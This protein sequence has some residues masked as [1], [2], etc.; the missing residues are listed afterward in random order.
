MAACSKSRPRATRC[1]YGL[2]IAT[3]R[4]FRGTRTPRP[5]RRAARLGGRRILRL[6]PVSIDI[7]GEREEGPGKGL[8]A[9]IV[10]V[11]EQLLELLGDRSV[12][13]KVL[14]AP[15][16]DDVVALVRRRVPVVVEASAPEA[17]EELRVVGEHVR[18]AEI[19]V[20]QTAFAI[21]FNIGNIAI[22]GEARVGR[23]SCAGRH[24][25]DVGVGDGACGALAQLVEA[26]VQFVLLLVNRNGGAEP[27]L[28]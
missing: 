27:I 22:D 23:P 14:V 1:T 24:K 18:V 4:R 26:L 9:R 25:E 12:P 20:R 15:L 5:A 21:L 11:L 7:R 28:F 3:S 8:R 2:R 13:R 19:V 6:Q 16:G 17:E 10:L